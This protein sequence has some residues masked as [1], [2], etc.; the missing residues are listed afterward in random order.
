[1]PQI[2]QIASLIAEDSLVQSNATTTSLFKGHL[3][4]P[5][6]LQV[7]PKESS[8]EFWPSVVLLMVFILLVFIRVRSPK[9]ILYVFKSFFSFGSAI[10]LSR[11]EYKL[12]K[13]TSIILTSIFLLTFP[14]FLYYLNIYYGFLVLNEVNVLNYLLIILV[15]ISVYTVKI[16]FLRILGFIINVA[17]AVEEY[18]F[19]FFILSKATGIF[20]FPILLLLEFVET[21]VLYL[22]FFGVL[23][24]LFFYSSRIIRGYFIVRQQA[25]ISIFHLFL[26]FCT[27]EIIPLAVIIKWVSVN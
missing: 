12:N 27:L 19:N 26:Y 23:M 20:L 3:L 4:Q 11:E 17:D 24:V 10:Q 9:K 25:E 6:N 8:K 22:L 5:V 14:L 16:I 2:N 15:V 1:M 21:K 7:L 18:I 13:G